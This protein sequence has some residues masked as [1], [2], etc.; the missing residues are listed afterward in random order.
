MTTFVVGPF[1]FQV[2]LAVPT[3]GTTALKRTFPPGTCIPRLWPIESPVTWHSN[4]RLGPVDVVAFAEQ[5]TAALRG[6]DVISTPIG[7]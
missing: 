4:P 1:V 5:I 2:F 7:S 6:S 3:L